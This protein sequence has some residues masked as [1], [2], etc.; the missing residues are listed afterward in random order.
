VFLNRCDYL[1]PE[2][3]WVGVKDSG[4]GA[5]LSTVGYEQLTRPKSF[6]LRHPLGS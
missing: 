4:R 2:L 6:H 3:A 1:D 5:T